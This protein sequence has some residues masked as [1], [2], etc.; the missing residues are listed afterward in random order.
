MK[1]FTK[2]MLIIA[3]V[4]ASVGVICMVLAFSMGLTTGHFI[5]LIQDGRF[6]FDEGDF[7]ISLGDEGVYDVEGEVTSTEIQGTKIIKCEI[8]ESCDRI[9]IEFGA[10]WIAVGYDDVEHIEISFSEGYKHSVKIKNG[11]LIIKGNTGIG[12]HDNELDASYL[13][14]KIPRDMH[15]KEVTMDL[16]ASQA[17]IENL[18]VEKLALEVGA[19]Q[20]D[21][22]RLIVDELK[23]EVGVGQLNIAMYGNEFDYN[24][25]IECGVGQIKIGETSYSGLAS[26][27]EIYDADIQKYVDVECGIGEVNIKFGL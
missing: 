1:K 11:T 20:A 5:K 7:H 26:A 21:V 15:F 16:G 18:N 10:G 24:Y 3:G 19:G 17:H 4:L 14:I 13:S 6:S 2:I 12:I 22:S 23:A 25:R 9:D 8:E 27:H